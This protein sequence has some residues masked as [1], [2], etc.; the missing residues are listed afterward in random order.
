M[1][2]LRISTYVRQERGG[3][4]KYFLSILIILTIVSCTTGKEIIRTD[5]IVC[6]V[7]GRYEDKSIIHYK[8]YGLDGRHKDMFCHTEC[9]HRLIKKIGGER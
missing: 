3:R 8:L 7:C 4:M 2:R 5:Y 6:D 9:F 1:C